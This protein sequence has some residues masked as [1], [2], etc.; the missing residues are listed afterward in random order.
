MFQ[1][2]EASRA[3]LSE[4]VDEVVEQGVTK[5]DELLQVCL[6]VFRCMYACIDICIH[7][8]EQK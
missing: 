3:S 7:A 5:K 2:E 6:R 1:E 4:I 8:H